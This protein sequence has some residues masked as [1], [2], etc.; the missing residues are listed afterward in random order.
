MEIFE[1]WSLLSCVIKK[2]VVK[3]ETEPKHTLQMKK[4]DAILFEITG[5]WIMSE[6]FYF[7]REE[8]QETHR[9]R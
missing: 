4:M 5:I 1:K 9:I 3:L 8:Y 2:S 7:G 6:E